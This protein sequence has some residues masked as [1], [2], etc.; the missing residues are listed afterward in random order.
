M[1]LQYM[2][3]DEINSLLTKINSLGEELNYIKTNMVQKDE[4]MTLT[5]FEA[6][7]KSFKKHN[8]LSLEEAKSQLGF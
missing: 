2:T 5:E 8:L 4:I 6:Y 3:M 7:K 1:Y